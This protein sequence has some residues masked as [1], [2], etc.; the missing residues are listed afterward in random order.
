L[1][2]NTPELSLIDSDLDLS[3]IDDE[4]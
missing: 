2:T 4:D 1:T 3:L